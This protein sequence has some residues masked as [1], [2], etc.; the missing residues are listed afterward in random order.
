MAMT[1]SAVVTFGS[2]GGQEVLT[3]ELDSRPA[4]L[5]NGKSSFEGTDRPVFLVCASVPYRYEV[6]LGSAVISVSRVTTDETADVIQSL[7]PGV[8]TVEI[9][10]SKPASA[11][12]LVYVPEYG[13][14]V[15]VTL[16]KKLADGRYGSVVLSIPEQA[17]SQVSVRWLVGSLNWSTYS[18]AIKVT[19][20]EDW[21]SALPPN[22]RIVLML[23]GT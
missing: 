9:S 22:A 23:S 1:A 3:A 16:S 12:S 14:E 21:A 7:Q 19:P 4:G 2:Q 8:N 6:S 20:P 13:E 11:G 5:N 17:A 15:T 18:T 10:L